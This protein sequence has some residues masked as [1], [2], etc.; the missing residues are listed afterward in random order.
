MPHQVMLAGKSVGAI[1]YGLMGLSSFSDIIPE[2]QAISTM[3]AAA[4]AGATAWSTAAF[5]GPPD[6]IFSLSANSLDSTPS[7]WTRS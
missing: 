2:D 3:Q 6:D 4:D 7:I 1:G 5:Y